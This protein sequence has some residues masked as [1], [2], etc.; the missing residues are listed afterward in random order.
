MDEHQTPDPMIIRLSSTEGNFFATVKSFDANIAISGNFVHV[1]NA[2]NSSGSENLWSDD[3]T[4]SPN[5]SSELTLWFDQCVGIQGLT[6]LQLVNCEDL[7]R[8][9]KLHRKHTP[10]RHYP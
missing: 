1:L 3:A 8:T 10:R 2:K 9:P 4:I 5:M 6:D 7:N